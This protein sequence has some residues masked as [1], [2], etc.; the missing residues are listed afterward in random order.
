MLWLAVLVMHYSSAAMKH[1]V[2]ASV[3]YLILLRNLKLFTYMTNFFL[4]PE[5]VN[6]NLNEG[7][8]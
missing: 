4:M 6:L 8:L 1:Q 7:R 3:A 2:A 5:I